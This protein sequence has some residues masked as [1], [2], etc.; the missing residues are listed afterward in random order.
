MAKQLTQHEQEAAK[1]LQNTEQ[2]HTIIDE[3][4]REYKS[5]EI[6]LESIEKGQNDLYYK[7]DTVE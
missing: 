1:N 3:M 2:L 4:N 6:S 7:L 5:I